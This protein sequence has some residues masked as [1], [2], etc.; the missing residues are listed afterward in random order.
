MTIN[1]SAMSTAQLNQLKLD[2][3]NGNTTANQAELNMVL[4]EL[5]FRGNEGDVVM[6]STATNAQTTQS[7]DKTNKIDEAEETQDAPYDQEAVAAT[8]ADIDADMEILKGYEDKYNALIAEQ[9]DLEQQCKDFDYGNL[10]AVQSSAQASAILKK[11][12]GQI[13]RIKTLI[14]TTE[15]AIR[16]LEEQKAVAGNQLAK[17]EAE[18]AQL[19]EEMEQLH[20]QIESNEEAAKKE[21]EQYERGADEWIERYIKEYEKSGMQNTDLDMQEWVSQQ[22]QANYKMSPKVQM[23]YD[24][25]DS[26]IGELNTKAEQ[27]KLVAG[28]IDTLNSKID[29][30]DKSLETQNGKLT[31]YN[32]NLDVAEKYK[33]GVIQTRDAWKKVEN[34][35]KKKKR[36]LGGLIKKLVNACKKVV[37]T[38]ISGVKKL[39]QG[40]T[41]AVGGVM[42][43]AGKFTGDI[44][45]PLGMEGLCEGIGNASAAAS[46]FVGATA[47]FDKKEMKQSLKDIENGAEM[48]VE[49]K[50]FKQVEK[51]GK[52]AGDAACDAWNDTIQGAGR[53]AGNIADEVFGAVGGVI[54][55]Y[56]GLDSLGN[57]IKA[58][59]ETVEG[60]T[61]MTSGALTG[62]KDL[63]DEGWDNTKD[64]AL[65]AGITVAKIIAAIYTGGAAGLIDLVVSEAATE[66][67]KSVGEDI[68]GT[69]GELIGGVVG[70]V[71]GSGY[72]SL[73]GADFDFSAV[74][75]KAV[76]SEGAGNF[77][78]EVGKN[79]LKNAAVVGG[80]KVAEEAGVDEDIAGYIGAGVGMLY[81]SATDG[82]KLDADRQYFSG[83]VI[84]DA[85]G[86]LSGEIG[87]TDA[88]NNADKIGTG[89]EVVGGAIADGAVVAG[90][91]IGDAAVATGK[92]VVG[93]G[94]AVV[95]GLSY[96]G[97]AIADGVEYVG[98][99]ISDGASYVGDILSP[100]GDA[101][102]DGAGYVGG[103]I[104]DGASYVGDILSPVGDAIAD[105]AG[106][107]GGL[108]SDGASYVGDALSPV[109]D[110]IADGA[111]ATWDG[112]KWIGGQ[113]SDGA[114][115]VGGLISYGASYV[116]DALSPV[117]NAIADGAEVAWDGIT[118]TGEQIADGASW[119]ADKTV[120]GINY[121][122]DAL[123]SDNNSE[124]WF[125]KG[126]NALGGAIDS[127][128][129]VIGE[130]VAPILKAGGEIVAGAANYVGDVA[131]EGYNML[132]KEDVI[133]DD[134]IIES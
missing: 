102:A 43:F 57:G 16:V 116:G 105:G 134:V 85:I 38:V 12:E 10:E 112:A 80:K 59:G 79:S 49:S 20:E 69:T 22:M 87:L 25:N 52:K 115:Y 123:S 75:D 18:E 93:A 124:T 53:L 104:S 41:G 114:G 82:T 83:D 129:Q 71:A 86:K 30:I 133:L 64:N 128:S 14:K 68:G 51:Y 73:K 60:T 113:I 39:I 95:G 118:W 70:A 126:A 27:V 31:E 96:V 76:T 24:E 121:A 4:E 23:L 130:V 109:G 74:A 62:D 72:D 26:L 99:L 3:E 50:I 122:G 58:I 17:R 21:V 37:K 78:A 132:V 101:I 66:T 108:V 88:L 127:G 100:V 63:M 94:G 107:V 44:L 131:V 61:D 89:A 106:Y 54:D 55:K 46:E 125:V 47:T 90:Q 36:G 29:D 1:V 48:A 92:A 119:L 117:G 9:T 11:V 42:K 81:G 34:A 103:L 33:T 98:G 56:L 7:A 13:T 8:Q 35:R 19:E 110:A 45:K 120:N 5:Q 91:A 111:S 6:V 28:A 67:G 77:V 65:E 2:L 40:I 97:G 32:K 15:N 84:G